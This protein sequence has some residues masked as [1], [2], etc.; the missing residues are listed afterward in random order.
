[1]NKTVI[2]YINGIRERPGKLKNWNGRAVTWTHLNTDFIGE[3]LEYYTWFWTHAWAQQTRAKKYTKMIR[4]YLKKGFKVKLVCHSNGGDIGLR[5]LRR[6]KK[7][8]I[9]AIHLIAGACEADMA[10]NGVLSQ[11]ERG[12]LGEVKVYIGGQDKAM[13]AAR[14]S[15]IFKFAGFGYG[16][17]GGQKPQ[18]VA[19]QIGKENVIYKPKYDHND[20][21][22]ESGGNFNRT[23]KLLTK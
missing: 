3:K 19:K 9:E 20:W 10:K 8:K 22:Q 13:W 21:F 7:Y 18:D 5:I 23:M 12:L 6:L 15:K 2:V 11:L 14:A 16:N 1:M 17:L 4:M